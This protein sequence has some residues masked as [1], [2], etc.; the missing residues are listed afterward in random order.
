[1]LK[2][3]VGLTVL[4]S[5]PLI[6]FTIVVLPALSSP[7]QACVGRWLVTKTGKPAISLHPARARQQLTQAAP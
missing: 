3:S 1:M 6:R 5:S 2:P 4:A 7:L